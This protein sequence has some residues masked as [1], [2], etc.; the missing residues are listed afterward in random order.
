MCGVSTVCDCVCESVSVRCGLC[1]C[2][3]STVCMC[4]REE[5]IG[6]EQRTSINQIL[7]FCGIIQVSL[8]SSHALERVVDMRS[9]STHVDTQQTVHHRLI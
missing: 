7:P 1:R 2:M 4:V 5:R 9:Q 8:K 6:E 3:C